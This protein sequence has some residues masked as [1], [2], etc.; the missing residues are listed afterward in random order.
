MEWWKYPSKY[1]PSDFHPKKL[2]IL[3]LP[4]SLFMSCKLDSLF[5]KKLVALKVLN[6]DNS[7]FL[8]EIPDVS[9]LPSL[10]ELSF[11]GCNNLT[12]IH[13]SAG[14][15]GK[16]KIL[17]AEHCHKLRSFPSMNLPSLKILLLSGCS[18]LEKFPEMLGKMENVEMLRLSRT[19]IRDLPLSFRN[20]SELY[21]LTMSGNKIQRIPS[22]VFIMPKLSSF[23]IDGTQG[24]RLESQKQ[25]EGMEGIVTSFS[26][27][28]V[29]FLYL[30][31]SKLSDDFMV[32]QLPWFPNLKRLDLTRSDI[33]IIPEC[34]QE[35]QFLSRL[36]VDSCRHLLEIRGIP[37]NLQNFSALY[38]ESLTPSTTSML[39]NQELHEKGN[40][41]F[42]MPRAYGSIPSWFEHRS[43]E[44]NSISF[45][46][47]GKFP[48]KSLCLAILLNYS[49]EVTPIV[50]INGKK[51]SC[52]SGKTYV[53]RLFIF[54][55]WK[56]NYKYDSDELLF[57]SQEW[58]HAEVSWEVTA[59]EIGMHI[60]NQNCS[61]IM[62]DIRF[63][64][65]YR[66][67]KRDDRD[68]SQ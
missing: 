42:V 40:T 18:S 41:H 23:Y 26:S 45:W 13:S 35:F 51:V 38:C 58:N 32:Q 3:K 61:S 12:R 63:T 14:F 30:Y 19:D 9:N 37:P 6:F 46:F 47:R 59:A 17:N 65:P 31:F 10:E 11:R 15:L 53:E 20:L 52:G 49:Q 21:T 44:T 36:Q 66:K 8:K 4:N 29:R 54:D 60:L 68:F 24:N 28:S 2:S 33:T 34:I 56:T 25:D 27:S 57:E 64:H 16:L 5:T 22:V 55:L 67:R 62:Q 39:L 50:T 7:D 1:F 43:E 48:A